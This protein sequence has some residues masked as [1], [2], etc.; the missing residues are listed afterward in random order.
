MQGSLKEHCG[1]PPQASLASPD[2]WHES[3]AMVV[4]DR[5]NELSVVHGTVQFWRLG[6]RLRASPTDDWAS[7]QAASGR[8]ARLCRELLGLCQ[9]SHSGFQ[10]HPRPMDLVRLVLGVVNRRRPTFE[11]AAQWL[12]TEVP[13]ESI[14]LAA[15]GERLE[16]VL[17]NLLDNA[18][19][20]MA[21]GGNVTVRLEHCDGE[22]IVRVRDT[23]IG[24]S[25]EFLPHVFDPFARED[26][27]A[28]RARPGSGVGLLAVRRIVE[29]HG[30][31][32]EVAS[33]GRGHGSEFTLRLPT[34][35]G[36]SPEEE[37]VPSPA[38]HRR[39]DVRESPR[40]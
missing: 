19:K 34:L 32:V 20:Y 36:P 31:R 27:A 21:A 5:A 12:R 9:T 18:A 22:V 15:D 16:R 3:L 8:A 29:L 2:A 25:A 7:V 10:L 14:W 26:N 13:N 1:A 30:G 28:V 23:G 6:A 24:I 38:F 39:C 35:D 4:H 37:H 11:S 17:D 33:T 40:S